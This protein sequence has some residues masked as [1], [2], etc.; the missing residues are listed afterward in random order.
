MPSAWVGGRCVT[1]LVHPVVGCKTR[2][3]S[4]DDA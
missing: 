4:Q 2:D 3:R 1:G